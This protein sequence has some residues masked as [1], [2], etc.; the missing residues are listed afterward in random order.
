[1]R[2]NAGCGYAGAHVC[3]LYSGFV[4]IF[5]G[6]KSLSLVCGHTLNS[7]KTIYTHEEQ[8]FFA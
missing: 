2:G 7:L 3:T 8:W 4:W 6:E 1:M 5:R